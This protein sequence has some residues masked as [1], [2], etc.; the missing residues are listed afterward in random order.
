[1]GKR[2]NANNK[3]MV[4]KEFGLLAIPPLVSPF[5]TSRTGTTE[6]L[7]LPIVPTPIAIGTTSYAAVL[8]ITAASVFNF[9]NYAANWEEYVIR[10]I[11]WEW[12]AC[13]SQNGTIKA[14]IDEADNSNPTAN[15]ARAH[16][17]FVAPCKGESGFRKKLRWT[18]KDTGDETWRA[19]SNTSTF[20]TALKVYSDTTTWGLV[21]TAEC[22]AVVNAW[23]CVQFRTQGGA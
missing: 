12:I 3:Q 22:V 19:T 16:L 13:G 10:A 11:Q 9:A 17:G 2:R 8:S 15:T 18:A 7:W 21:G 4:S 20:I 1:M 5:S 14:Y 6:I 23:A